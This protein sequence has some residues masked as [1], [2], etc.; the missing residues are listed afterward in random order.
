L[1]NEEGEG[2][3]GYDLESSKRHERRTVNAAIYACYLQH[4]NPSTRTRTR[5]STIGEREEEGK[6]EH[7]HT[8]LERR[9]TPRAERRT[10]NAE[11]L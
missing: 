2:I 9:R 8:T 11:R 4:K 5:T 3:G 6:G 1:G 10:P 7:D